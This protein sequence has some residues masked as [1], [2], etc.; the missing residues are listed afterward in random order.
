MEHNPDPLQSVDFYA[1]QT[2]R[3]TMVTAVVCQLPGEMP[4]G[5]E[6]TDDVTGD[7]E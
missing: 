7:A 3:P 4:Y 1:T 6:E 2:L 5:E